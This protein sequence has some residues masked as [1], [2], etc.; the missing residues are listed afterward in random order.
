MKQLRQ[1][2][3]KLL[4]HKLDDDFSVSIMTTGSG[5]T[6]SVGDVLNTSGNN[7]EGDSIFTLGGS[8]TGK[9]LTL[10]FGD[11]LSRS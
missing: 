10:D 3:T 7:Y 6:G 5:G 11:K 9:T 8:L 1:V 2:Q 4:Y